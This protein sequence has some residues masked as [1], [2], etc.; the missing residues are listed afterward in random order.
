LLTAFESRKIQTEKERLQ[1]NQ[2][3]NNM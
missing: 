1:G 3:S 2:Q